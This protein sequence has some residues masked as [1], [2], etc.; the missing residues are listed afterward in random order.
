MYSQKIF[1]SLSVK[2]LQIQR[3][4]WRILMKAL[5]YIIG[6]LKVNLSLS[7]INETYGGV[8]V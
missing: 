8:G 2:Y 4:L 5:L 3:D 1:Y 6:K 7:L